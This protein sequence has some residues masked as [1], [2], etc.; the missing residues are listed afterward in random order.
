[1]VVFLS[2]CSAGEKP[3]PSISIKFAKNIIYDGPK[4]LQKGFLTISP[5]DFLAEKLFI[6]DYFFEQLKK[7]RLLTNILSKIALGV[8]K[9]GLSRISLI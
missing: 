1:M 7:A 6:F 4:L 2:V 9:H 5:I 3:T 8:I